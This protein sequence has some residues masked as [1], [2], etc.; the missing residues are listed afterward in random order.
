MDVEGLLHPTATSSKLLETM[1]FLLKSDFSLQTFNFWMEF[2]EASFDF[3]DGH[4]GDIWL[5]RALQILLEKSSYREHIDIG[6]ED[7]TAYRVDVVDVFEGICEVLG[8]DIMNSIVADYLNEAGH[9]GNIQDRAV[10]SDSLRL[11]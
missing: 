10:V 7:W 8:Y 5:K 4:S 1:L 9:Q 3:D 6:I 2:V 11:R